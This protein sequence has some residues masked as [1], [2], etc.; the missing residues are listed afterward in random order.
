MQ[1]TDG[2]FRSLLA[3]VASAAEPISKGCEKANV[4]PVREQLKYQ[5]MDLTLPLP[6]PTPSDKSAYCELCVAGAWWCVLRLLIRSVLR[7]RLLRDPH[8][9]CINDVH[10]WVIC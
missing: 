1:I 7:F 8:A 4:Q 5:P 9:V 3:L 2:K 10:T 6:A